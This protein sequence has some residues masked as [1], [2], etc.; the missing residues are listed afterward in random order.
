MLG[1]LTNHIWQSTL[2]AVAAGLM[3]LAFRKNRAQVRYWLWLSAS[4]KFL[5]P[6]SLLMSLGARLEW[7]P[8]M[9]KMTTAPAVSFTLVQM[10][11]PFPETSSPMPSTQDTRDWVAF[12]LLA[13]WACGLSGVA[14]IRYRGWRR[15]R[16]A[17][18][19]S[20]PIDISAAVAVRSSPGL[21]EPGVVGLFRPILLLPGNIME[22]LQPRE[23]QAVLAHELCHVRRRDNL[24]SA[25]HM[26]VEGVFWFHPLVWWIGA[27]LVDER[28]RACDEAV[29]S[30]VSE[31]HDYAIAILSV[32]K[33]YLESPLSCVSGVTGADLKKR[34]QAILMGRPA[35][36]LNVVKK[37][38]LAVAGL[39]ALTV[40][41]VIGIIGAP[42]IRAQSPSATTPKF[43]TVSIKPCPAFR[44][45]STAY[46]P[47]NP[48]GLS[49]TWRSECTTVQYLVR[50]A[51]LN[52]N[53]HA[54]PLSY[55]TVTGGP[56]WTR[57]DLYEIEV[58]AEE[59]QSP[60]MMNGPI[61][62]AI[63][64][65]RF[66]L[67][68]HRETRE[69]P[70]YE[71]MVVKGGPKL[72]P[73]QGTCTPWDYDH[74]NPGPQQCATSRRTSH[75]VD[76]KGWTIADLLYFFVVTLDRPVVDE[77]K[78][79]GRYDFHLEL[80]ENPKFF[81]R[82]R[83]KPAFGDPAV[84]ATDPSIVSEIKT[85]IEKLGLNLEPATGPGEFLVI[86]HIE[87]PSAN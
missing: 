8:V 80:P 35:R 10:S 24:T 9:Q 18:R 11:Q 16:A 77:T 30:L 6:F 54:N 58:K 65:D 14:L 79:T 70:I 33:N 76:M 86:E 51:G 38:A 42:R 75:G 61:L 5:L 47:S 87:R 25:V 4:L 41:L 21:L 22:R 83:G 60:I 7:A 74:P 84:P 64:E 68:V 43:E 49:R 2:F 82:A 57:S 17:V 40:P 52:G 3:T 37:F 32:C 26:I 85:G 81:R 12:V 34:I 55:V 56:A 67:R 19:C 45:S 78:V 31:P 73:F 63:L 72:Q 36:D 29:L 66:K 39:T 1:E 50:Q 13:L 23:L 27:R 20:S 44:K 62:Q 69:V 71:L 59:P 15:I 28:E 46:S 53:G 48:T